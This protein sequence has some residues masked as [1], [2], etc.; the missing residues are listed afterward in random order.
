MAAAVREPD[1]YRLLTFLHQALPKKKKSTEVNIKINLHTNQLNRN[2]KSVFIT[3][4]PSQSTSC[5]QQVVIPRA[6]NKSS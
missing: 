2:Q 4:S 1:L 3:L 5:G 6:T